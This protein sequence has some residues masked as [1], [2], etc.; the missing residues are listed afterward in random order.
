MYVN[1]GVVTINLVDVALSSAKDFDCFWDVFEERL[2]LCHRALRYRHERLLGTLSDVAPILWQDGA[3][4]RLK[5]GEKIDKL[6]YNGYSTIS[7]GYAGLYECVKYMTGYSLTQ[8]EGKNFGLQIMQKMKDKC[9]EW[10]ENE[11]IDYSPYGTPIENTTYKFA[12]C[13]RKRFGI[14]EGI[15]DRK[16]ITNSYHIPVFEEINPFEKLKTESEF[17]KLSA[18]GMISYVEASDLSH[19]IDIVL[20]L[21]QF[22]YDNIMY[23]EINTKSDYCQ[24]CGYD[25]EIKLVDENGELIWECPQ[26]HNRDKTK[27]NVSRRTCGYIGSNFWNKGRT[28]EI[29]ERYVHLDDHELKE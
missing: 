17:Q 8:E 12:T 9:D 1:Q 22:I 29:S 19:N 27:M 26:C 13:L 6:L 28:E 14:I 15:T 20:D 4:A 11:N 18:G 5:Q 10:K 2:E 23:A 24:V 7:L 25:G 3:F 16:Y 21:I